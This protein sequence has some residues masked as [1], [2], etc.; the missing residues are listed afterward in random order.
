MSGHSPYLTE[1][2]TTD[3]T[4]PQSVTV[5]E[6]V[7]L[8]RLEHQKDSNR[9]NALSSGSLIKFASNNGINT[10]KYLMSWPKLDNYDRGKLDKRSGSRLIVC[11]IVEPFYTYELKKIQGDQYV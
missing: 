1:N 4:L 2:N 9:L 7:T 8:L 5:C 10:P 3:A 11:I 6:H